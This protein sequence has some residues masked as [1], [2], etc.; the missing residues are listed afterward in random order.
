MDKLKIKV[1]EADNKKLFE[2]QVLN[3]TEAPRLMNGIIKLTAKNIYFKVLKGKTG[4]FGNS[5]GLKQ[6][7][8][9][10]RLLFP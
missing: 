5:A 9:I 7:T 8:R 3:F 1:N 4:Y 10:G 2:R 6:R